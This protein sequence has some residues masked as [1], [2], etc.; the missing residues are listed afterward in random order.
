LYLKE[1]PMANINPKKLLIIL[2][3]LALVVG[4]ITWAATVRQPK[5]TTVLMIAGSGSDRPDAVAACV[6]AAVDRII[7]DGATVHIAPV[8]RS[9]S[10]LWKRI[11]TALNGAAKTNPFEAGKQRRDAR[12]AVEREL[13]RLARGPRPPGSSDTLAAT[14]RWSPACV[15]AGP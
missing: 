6:D 1:K 11:P 4:G 13:D 2:A 3:S 9:S 15:R 5:G 7:K 12:V 8:G 10:A 14:A